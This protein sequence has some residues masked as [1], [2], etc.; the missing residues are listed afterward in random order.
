MMLEKMSL[1]ETIKIQNFLSFGPEPMELNLKPLN[2]LIGPNGSGKSNL[3]E[4][5]DLMRS[6]PV[7]LQDGIRKKGGISQFLWK[8]ETDSKAGI[9]LTLF[10]NV[11]D[12]KKNRPIRHQIS[13]SELGDRFHLNGELVADKDCMNN[14]CQI[15]YQNEKEQPI[16][17]AYSNSQLSP[18]TIDIADKSWAPN[19][20]I[21]QQRRDPKR[22]PQLTSITD[23]YRQICI[24][25]DINVSKDSYARKGQKTDYKAD[26]LDEDLY[27]LALVI[28]HLE[29]SNMWDS[30]LNY[31]QK[32][33]EP[34][35]R[36]TTKIENGNVQVY[37]HERGLTHPI[38]A[39]RFSD[40]FLRFLSLL[41]V[42]IHPDPPPLICIEEPELGMHPDSLP[43]LA[44]LLKE[45]AERTQL[46][47]T[48]HSDALVNEFTDEPESVVVCEKE[49]GA[50]TFK[51]LN[52]Q[53]LSE[54]LQKYSLGELWRM[55][56]IGG[57]RW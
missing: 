39:T 21:L 19:Q 27:N 1:I 46:I 11:F 18:E 37:L 57:N 24:Y 5:I 56:E 12:R 31:L 25:R 9:E 47:V 48:T 10:L 7:D 52:R 49:F 50:T 26:F 22:Y 20:S 43:I 15:Y 40:G 3:I 53:A 35:E 36:I 17:L 55:G 51:R 30:F 38:P 29:N 41:V 14:Q 54:W 6:T 4:A 42:L 16:I 32:F 28:N 34:L 23:E 44:A 13:F 8:G 2:I 45:A 33:Y